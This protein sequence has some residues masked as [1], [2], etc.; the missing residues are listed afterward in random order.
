MD[1]LYFL[2]PFG[3]LVLL[4]LALL[5]KFGDALDRYVLGWRESEEGRRL[6]LRERLTRTDDA[7]GHGADGSWS[8]G[9]GFGGGGDGGGG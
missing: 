8:D 1:F 9:G 4:P 7:R 5:L 2:V 3:L 6:R